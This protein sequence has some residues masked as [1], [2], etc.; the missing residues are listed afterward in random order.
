[1]ALYLGKSKASIIQLY[2]DPI[3][4]VENTCLFGPFMAFS[5]ELNNVFA[6]DVNDKVTMCMIYFPLSNGSSILNHLKDRYAMYNTSDTY[7]T[8]I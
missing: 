5:P 1:M 2:G 3:K 4:T 8:I 6:F 7:K